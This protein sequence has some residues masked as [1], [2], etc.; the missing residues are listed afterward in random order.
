MEDKRLCY[1]D[2]VAELEQ[3][4]AAKEQQ[5][6]LVKTK[7]DEFSQ[8][9][10]YLNSWT[11]NNHFPVLEKELNE[12][13]AHWSESASLEQLQK[14]LADY[15]KKIKKTDQE[16]DSIKILHQI[17]QQKP[18]RHGCKIVTDALSAFLQRLPTISLDKLDKINND[19]FP[20]IHA[21]IEEVLEGF[22]NENTKVKR[23][24]QKAKEL[25]RWI[26]ECDS[27][28]DRFNLRSLCALAL[29]VVEHVLNSPD[30]K[31]PEADKEQLVQAKLQLDQC[32]DKF[33]KEDAAYQALLQSLNNNKVYF[34]S[35]DYDMLEADLSKGAF[36]NMKTV[37][38]LQNQYDSIKNKK[39]NELDQSLLKYS[40]K[41][42]NHFS[43]E[44][45]DLYVD[46]CSKRALY[47]LI[48]KMDRQKA[49]DNKKLF[50][51]ILKILGC[52]VGVLV[53]V[54]LVTAFPWI[55]LIPIVIA[56]LYFFFRKR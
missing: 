10:S 7:R 31:N 15:Y 4:Y 26:N 42:K 40:Q 54:G 2:L 12:L 37:A 21:K 19:N 13:I 36:H 50:F 46:F 6:N 49:E 3:L 56:A 51:L 52:I 39:K 38:E 29:K 5:E 34:W 41:I 25:K 17:L 24:Q 35:E 14:T 16:T 23:N 1:S 55:L 45:N 30:M 44:I 9:S 8:L 22:D 53:I 11:I 43:N 48:S 47:D 27:Y 18:D 20:K 33:K 32:I 28:V